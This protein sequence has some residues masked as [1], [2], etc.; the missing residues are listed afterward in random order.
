MTPLEYHIKIRQILN[1]QKVELNDLAGAL[2][3]GSLAARTGATPVSDEVLH[4]LVMAHI[5]YVLALTKVVQEY[6][7]SC[8]K[9]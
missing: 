2:V 1:R 8:K 7:D 3:S 9:S 6:L 4:S 5:P